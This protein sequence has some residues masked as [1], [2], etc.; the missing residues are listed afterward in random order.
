MVYYVYCLVEALLKDMLPG[1]TF[2]LVVPVAQ[3][4]L[5]EGEWEKEGES[6][7]EGNK[8]LPL[9]INGLMQRLVHT[10]GSN[11]DSLRKRI[12]W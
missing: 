12:V 7:Q 6:R 11:I 4:Y 10:A 5:E 2:L 9:S 3:E 8:R 1:L